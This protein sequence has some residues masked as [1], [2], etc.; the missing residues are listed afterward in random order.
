[1]VCTVCAKFDFNWLAVKRTSNM[2]R[3]QWIEKAC[4]N[5]AALQRSA[6]LKVWIT[7]GKVHYQC[8]AGTITARCGGIFTLQMG[9]NGM[10]SKRM[11]VACH[12]CR[13]IAMRCATEA[14]LQHSAALKVW[15]AHGKVHYQCRAGTIAARIGG[16]YIFTPQMGCNVM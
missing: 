15:T 6:A 2:I 9:R 5:E 12:S 14:A 8:R 1:M 13:D 7:H 10:Y 11:R 4:A 3:R 16:I